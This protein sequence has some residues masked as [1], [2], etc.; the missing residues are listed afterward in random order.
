MAH[1][2]FSGRYDR[3]MYQVISR[4][5]I[6]LQDSPVYSKIVIEAAG[7]TDPVTKPVPDMRK[8]LVLTQ[9]TSTVK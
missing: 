6:L 9:S 8:A 3:K 7:V 1:I 4:I 2:F 5:R